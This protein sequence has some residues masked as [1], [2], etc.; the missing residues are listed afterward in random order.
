[1][2]IL[3][4]N[5]PFLSFFQFLLKLCKNAVFKFSGLTQVA[6]PFSLGCLK[7]CILNLLFCAPYLPYLILSAA[8]SIKSIAL[9]G[10]NLSVIYRWDR[11]AA[12]TMAESAILTP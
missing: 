8:S 3:N 2:V 10:R 6:P 1:M 9:P 12:A 5:K 11:V 7:L 4:L